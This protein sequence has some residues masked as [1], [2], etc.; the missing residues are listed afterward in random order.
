MTIG[1]L[2][3]SLNADKE[4]NKDFETLKET[5]NVLHGL[6]EEDE[7]SKGKWG[8]GGRL[9]LSMGMSSDFEEALKA[10]SDIVRVGTSIF[11]QRQTQ[12]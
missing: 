6:L 4:G 9:L 1:A 5:R 7:D 3:H 2:A 10:G 8:E 11:G 12:A